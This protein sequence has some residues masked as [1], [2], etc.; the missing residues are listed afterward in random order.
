MGL[1]LTS[2]IVLMTAEQDPSLRASFPFAPRI[3]WS[4]VWRT[5][6]LTAS[7]ELQPKELAVDGLTYDG[8]RPTNAGTSWLQVT[9]GA[10]PI[11]YIGV[12]AFDLR[13]GS[14]KPQYKP[15]DTWLDLG[16]EVTQPQSGPVV[17]H[18]PKAMAG[19]YRILIQGAIAPP[20]IGVVMGGLAMVPDSGL[21]I[22]WEPPSLN[23]TEEYTN[24][25]SERGQFLSRQ[26]KRFGAS[27][28]VSLERL[29][30]RYGRTTWQ[31]F[32]LHARRRGFFFWW[33][34]DGF[35]E[36]AYGGMTSKFARFT[37]PERLAMGFTME[38]VSI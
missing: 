30:Y 21:P 23:P 18:F 19:D 3:G 6:T 22:G 28:D 5:G 7:S 9:T 11:D 31:Q 26:I 33:S 14:I 27:I 34:Y 12:A 13:N 24:S 36:V 32:Q 37:E 10:G 35:A 16:A 2:N 25:I 29:T 20:T 8:W 4:D 17:W 38:G 1:V 15:G